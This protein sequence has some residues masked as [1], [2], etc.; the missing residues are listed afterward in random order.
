MASIHKERRGDKIRYRVQFYDKDNR[1]RSIRL[2]NVNKKSADSIRAKVEDLLS[3]SIAG[4][5]P[6]SETTQWLT[7]QVGEDMA[8]KLRRA[9]FGE[10]WGLEDTE[11]GRGAPLG[12]RQLGSEAIDGHVPQDERA[13]QAVARHAVVPGIA[14]GSQ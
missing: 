5:R 3:A 4:C 7:S 11:R 14:S 6:S 8:A 2:G 1:R 9:G 10:V 12:A 13:G